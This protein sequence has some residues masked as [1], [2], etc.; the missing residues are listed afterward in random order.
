MPMKPSFELHN[1]I[2]YKIAWGENIIYLSTG[3]NVKNPEKLFTLNS[4]GYPVITYYDGSV[5]SIGDATFLRISYPALL[6]LKRKKILNFVYIDEN[7]FENYCY[8]N[9]L[10]EDNQVYFTKNLKYAVFNIEDVVKIVRPRQEK[11]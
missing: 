5:F 11:N 1:V 6:L 10:L 4:Y 8:F 7:G 3:K 9:K 2:G